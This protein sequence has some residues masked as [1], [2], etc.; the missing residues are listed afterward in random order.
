MLSPTR[1]VG[2]KNVQP[3]T[4]P[5]NGAGAPGLGTLD[6]PESAAPADAQGNDAP[7]S[8]AP[9]PTGEQGNGGTSP[10]S[11]FPGDPTQLPQDVQPFYKG[12]Q[13]AFTRAQQ[14]AKAK[15]RDLDAKLRQ[16]DDTLRELNLAR[17]RY[18]A[19]PGQ[20]PERK[21]PAPGQPAPRAPALSDQE[22]SE[23]VTA[24]VNEKR[25]FEALTLLADS[26]TERKVGAV[27]QDYEKRLGEMQRRLD[28]MQ[29]ETRSIGMDRKIREAWGSVSAEHPEFTAPKV[30]AEISS[31]LQAPPPRLAALLDQGQHEAAL[32]LAGLYALRN[33]E[34]GQAVTRA[35]GRQNAGRPGPPA[36]PAPGADA[37]R[38]DWKGSTREIMA[39]VINA[40]PAL[41]AAAGSLRFN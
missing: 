1:K 4:T 11:F 32:E 29:G 19:G 9:A 28:E 3:E 34:A 40:D 2:G 15:E 38:I 36:A 25:P 30:S 24:L 18:E 39:Q 21:D 8:D 41:K 33:I 37:S 7:G 26:V 13:A 14:S 20:G 27:A 10:E 35:N 17:A 31:I 12:M 16:A 22:L 6:N 5:D 23:R